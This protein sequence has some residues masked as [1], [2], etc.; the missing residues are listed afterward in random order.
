VH[1]WLIQ[2]GTVFTGEGP[3]FAGDVAIAGGKV[4]E[5]VPAV[6]AAPAVDRPA[7]PRIDTPPRRLIDARGLWVIPGLI[8]PHVHLALPMKGTVSSDDIE[9]GTRAALHGGVTTLIDFAAQP[10]GR[11]LA[12]AL[13]ERLSEFR[14]RAWCDY[15]LHA[16]VTDFGGAPD[17]DPYGAGAF[18][19]RFPAGLEDLRSLGCAS[20][21]IFTTYSREGMRIPPAVLPLVLRE[22]GARG[23]VVLV[24]AEDDDLV[25]AAT[26]D[27]LRAGRMD[28][29]HFGA[30]RPAEAEARAVEAVITAA[31]GTEARIYFVHVSTRAAIET[32]ERARD[33]CRGAGRSTGAAGIHAETCPQYLYLTEDRYASDRAGLFVVTPPLR[34]EGD[35]A[36]LCAALAA[37]R[38][39][40]IATDHCPFTRAQKD[41]PG[42]AF[43]EIPSGLPGIETRLPL[44]HSLPDCRLSP[45]RM[46]ELLSTAPARI[47]GLYPRKGAIR[48]GSDADIV[49][50]DPGERWIVSAGALHMRT[51]DSP[52]EGTRVR[53]RVRS[54]LLR[55]TIVLERGE[56]VEGPAGE[57]VSRG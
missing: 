17:G 36:G 1:D 47:F 45:E 57:F 27:L 33:A 50:F 40:V 32:I 55:G 37:G 4:A 6:D 11:T 51:D 31:A 8:D 26:D 35:R 20:L 44:V 49:L 19:S 34:S 54:V 30:S 23:F 21:K 16:N 24:H 7:D 18:E 10:P 39:D 3:G 41:R 56:T 29:R 12:A 38:I 22:A 52:Y 42:L 53:G 9:S 48:L 28:A 25:R 46:V 43:G 2:G 13:E 5:I 15:A 14:G